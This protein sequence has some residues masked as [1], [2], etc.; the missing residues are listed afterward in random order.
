M[1]YASSLF[2]HHGRS[3]V[4]A[5]NNPEEIP[6]LVARII[7]QRNTRYSCPSLRIVTFSKIGH[8]LR[9]SFL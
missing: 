9:S 3:M 7:P 2:R 8:T 1:L 4:A 5:E 6:A